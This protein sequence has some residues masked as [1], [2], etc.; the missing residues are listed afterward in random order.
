MAALTPAPPP[1]GAA[2]AAGAATPADVAA[3]LAAQLRKLRLQVQQ[4]DGEIEMLLGMLPPQQQRQLRARQDAAP[5]APG[6]AGCGK[7]GAAAPA[8]AGDQDSGGASDQAPAPGPRA[9]QQRGPDEA[10]RRGEGAAGVDARVSA[11][12]RGEQEVLSA[13]LDVG[14]LSDRNK[15]FEAFRK[16]YKHN[17][18]RARVRACVFVCSM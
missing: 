15:A 17:E 13:L 18:V 10:Q 5:P 3:D 14:L 11:A 2:R 7:A 8:A 12:K 4:R 9:Q 1:A 6:D 16:S